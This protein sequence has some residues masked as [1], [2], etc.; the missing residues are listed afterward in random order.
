MIGELAE[1]ELRV[2]IG[3]LDSG[4]RVDGSVERGRK[5]PELDRARPER[6]AFAAILLVIRHECRAAERAACAPAPVLR[7]LPALEAR[8][9]EEVS[10]WGEDAWRGTTSRLHA[11]R[12]HCVA[13]LFWC[14][15]RS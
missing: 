15:L 4:Q 12:A 14:G 2:A 13:R 10:A 9:V 8:G 11:H 1:L 6:K 3:E 5:P 7:L